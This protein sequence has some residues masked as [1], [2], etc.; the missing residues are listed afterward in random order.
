MMP[1]AKL[2]GGGLSTGVI[3]AIA[4]GVGGG[5][6]VLIAVM[7][8]CV[9]R[10]SRRKAALRVR[11]ETAPKKVMTPQHAQPYWEQNQKEVSPGRV[12][13]YAL[14]Q[15]CYKHGSPSRYSPAGSRMQRRCGMQNGDCPGTSHVTHWDGLTCPPLGMSACRRICY[16]QGGLSLCSSAWSQAQ[17]NQ[18]SVAIHWKEICMAGLPA[19]VMEFCLLAPQH[20][21]LHRSEVEDCRPPAQSER[22]GQHCILKG[23]PAIKSIDAAMIVICDGAAPEGCGQPSGDARQLSGRARKPGRRDLHARGEMHG[24]PLQCH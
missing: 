7:V 3:V 24:Q 14:L 2:T 9:L 16:S 22:R 23:A 18:L 13:G 5:A 21:E 19:N 4:V 17:H 20:P 12:A 11:Q 1:A 15:A 10:R 6:L 8:T